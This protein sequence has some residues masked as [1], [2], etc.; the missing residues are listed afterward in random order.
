[1]RRKKPAE[2]VT[3]PSACPTAPVPV[4][5]PEKPLTAEE[6]EKAK[7]ARMY[8]NQNTQAA[9]VE[10]QG[11]SHDKRA[12]DRL[13]VKEILPAFEK[14]V[15]NLINI[16][17][18][19]SLHDTYEDLKNDCVNF[20]FETIG[21]FDGSRGTNAFSYFNVVAKR[22][23]IIRTK[24]KNLRI[25]RNVSLDDPESMNANEHRIVEDHCTVPGQDVILEMETAGSG[26]LEMLYDIR[27]KVKTE[28]ELACINSIITIFE[29]IDEIDFLNKSAIL[30]YMR[31][32]SGL[33][34][35]QLT[36]TMQQVKR[37]Y[38][39]MKIEPKFKLW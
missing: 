39:R 16:H 1:M 3:Q 22:W 26:I 10:C 9:I 20:L 35:K 27:S 17:K 37:H 31:E 4:V 5:I 25:R 32:L 29:N 28:N 36:T 14:L 38:K 24:Q 34:P 13:Y 30:L 19:T 21:K 7:A 15:E 11:L 33:S 8:F 18:F 6:K 12:R 23:L 2:E